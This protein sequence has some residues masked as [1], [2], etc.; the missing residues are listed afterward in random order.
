MSS[1][2]VA[3]AAFTLLSM[4][5]AFAAEVNP[6][7][8]ADPADVIAINILLLP[9]LTMTAAAEVLNVRVRERDP[10]GFAFDATHI[11]HISLLHRFVHKSDLAKVQ[12]VVTQTVEQLRPTGWQLRATHL[13]STPWDGQA[14][15]NI[16]IERTAE[17]A[18]LQ[19][20]LVS[21]LAPIAVESGSSRAFVR[22]PNEPEPSAK[23][24]DYVRTFV[25]KATGKNFKPHVTAAIGPKQTI[26]EIRAGSFNAMNFHVAGVAIFQLGDVGTAR[27]VLW[28]STGLP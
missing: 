6:A 12:S 7:S 13:E 27:E 15:V 14:L 28:K 16:A 22:L 20:A 25:P 26:E 9:D 11:P 18:R 21:A 4:R 19:A 2:Y 23:T 17:L 8:G 10:T 24:V 5:T 1:L 3:I